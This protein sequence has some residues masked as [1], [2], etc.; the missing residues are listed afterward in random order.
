MEYICKYCNKKY[1][2]SHSRSNHY[3]IYHKAD[4]I[5]CQ[6]IV[7]PCV[8]PCVNLC[9][10]P[11]VNLEVDKKVNTELNENDKYLCIK[12]NI[13]FTTRYIKT[14]QRFVLI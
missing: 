10:N 12:C 14:N 11:C 9:V 7:N 3:R 13:K 2:S 8:N 1:K 5:T 4:N 6:P